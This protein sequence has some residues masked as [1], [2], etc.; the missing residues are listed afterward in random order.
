MAS[1]SKETFKCAMSEARIDS[2]TSFVSKKLPI[3]DKK[4]VFVYIAGST[5]FFSPISEAICRAIGQALACISFV[6]L[7]TGGCFGVAETTGRSFCEERELL[8]KE[9]PANLYHILPRYVNTV[10]EVLL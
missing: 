2:L 7:V 9:K 8:L 3:N 4:R 1:S 6:T 5:K 10:S